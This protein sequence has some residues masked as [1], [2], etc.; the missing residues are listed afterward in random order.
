MFGSVVVDVI[1]N[2][3][4]V[5]EFIDVDEVAYVDFEKELI[6]FKAHDA[7]IPR[8]LQVTRSSLLRV[9]RALF[10]KSI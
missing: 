6:C 5:E 9:K 4:L 2:D 3:G 7:L 8:M 10:Y 1:T